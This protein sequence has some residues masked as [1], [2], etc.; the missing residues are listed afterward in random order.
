MSWARGGHR[1]AHLV[2]EDFAN[3]HLCS[4]GRRRW[5]SVLS[6]REPTVGT[7]RS[8]PVSTTI[9]MVAL[10]EENTMTLCPIALVSGCKSCLAVSMCPLKT[11]IGDYQ[12]P[13][14]AGKTQESTGDQ[15]STKKDESA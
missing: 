5:P 14:E 1:Q 15:T 4:F 11:V 6:P 9:P 2:P 10:D 3:Q 12:K 8:A 13:A 7:K